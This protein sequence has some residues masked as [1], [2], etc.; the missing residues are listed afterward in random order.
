MNKTSHLFELNCTAVATC[1][2][3]GRVGVVGGNVDVSSFIISSHLV[4][5]DKVVEQFYSF[6]E[7]LVIAQ[8]STTFYLW[9][10]C[11]SIIYK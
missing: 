11:R 9:E 8:R 7:Y 10:T 2:S 4:I 5:A 1:A 6:R 3:F